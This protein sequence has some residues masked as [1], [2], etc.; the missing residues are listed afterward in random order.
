MR[1]RL[2]SALSAAWP[3]AGRKVVYSRPLSSFTDQ[4]VLPLRVCLASTEVMVTSAS[5]RPSYPRRCAR[6]RSS[7][8]ARHPYDGPTMSTAPTDAATATP[9]E[10]D[11][12]PQELIARAV[13][14]R[15][16]LIE[17]QADAEARSFYSEQMHQKFLDAG[18]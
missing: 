15:P 1:A 11:L 12:T 4:R 14:L 18:F 3:I 13:A 16:E 2:P 6:I 9:P 10:P 17:H 7:R 5:M 8:T